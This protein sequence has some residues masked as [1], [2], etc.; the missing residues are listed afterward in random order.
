MLNARIFVEKKEGFNIEAISL[1][2]TLNRNFNLNIKELRHL[3]VYDIFN[4][5]EKL[6]EQAKNVIFSEPVTDNIYDTFSLDGLTYIAVEFLPGQFDQRA[7]SA[8]QCLSL[9]DPKTEAVIKSAN[10]FILDAQLTP[11]QYAQ[12]KKYCINE[13]EARE[14]DMSELTLA[15][16]PEVQDVPIYEQFTSWNEDQLEQFRVKMGFAMS[17]ED[18]KFIQEYFKNEE[19]KSGDMFYLDSHLQWQ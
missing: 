19:K 2:D 11:E 14:K 7:D 10:L 4:I 15:E 3:K 12:I 16:N 17:L 8:M 1:K 18:L 5:D 13:V 6:L 9:L